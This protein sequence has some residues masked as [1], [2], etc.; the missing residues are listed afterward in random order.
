MLG[1]TS[2]GYA[3]VSSREQSINSNALAQQIEHLKAA[4]ASEI[5]VDVESGWKERS[6]T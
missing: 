3:R 5:L 2:L 6:R 1:N 4:G